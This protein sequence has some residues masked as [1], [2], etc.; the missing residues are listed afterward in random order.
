MTDI[1]ELR[2]KNIIESNENKYDCEVYLM[3]VTGKSNKKNK[4]L[5]L[6]DCRFCLIIISNFVRKVTSQQIY[7]HI[8]SISN[9]NGIA[10]E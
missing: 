7:Y 1:Y 4:L 3:R 8:C 9:I 6:D 5:L 10:I 2:Y